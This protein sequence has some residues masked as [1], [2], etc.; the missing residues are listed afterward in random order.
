MVIEI[1][2]R[3]VIDISH[4]NDVLSWADIKAAGVIGI[5]HKATEG[6]SYTDDTYAERAAE[7]RR[8]GL[9]WG[10]YHFATSSNAIDQAEH[11]LDVTGIH[12]DLLYALDWEDYGFDTMSEDQA[13]VFMAH[14]DRVTGRPCV[15]YGGNTIKEALG[16][17]Q[18][19]FFGQHRLW[20]AQYGFSPVEQ[21]SWEQYWLWQYSD[22]HAGPGPYGCPG[23]NGDVDTNS[24]P[25]SDDDLRREWSGLSIHEEPL[26]P[27][28]ERPRANVITL[29]IA[30][31]L[32]SILL[33]NGRLCRLD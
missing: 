23:V 17:E 11:F 2:N 32:R 12:D 5:I 15:V 6:T 1:P 28:V 8:H 19:E 27:D 4:H 25:H 21:P 24:W 29:D 20:L 9:L 3:K 16:S 13:R 31:S 7:A 14:V 22:G 26:P 30:T 10:A 33:V 18:D